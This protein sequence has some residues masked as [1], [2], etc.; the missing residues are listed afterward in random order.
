MDESREGEQLYT[1]SDLDV[2]TV[3][4]VYRGAVRKPFFVIKSAD[5]GKDMSDELKETV[6]LVKPEV[7][8]TS[9][10]VNAEAFAEQ[11][12]T[13]E[14][15]F[16]EQLKAEREKREQFSN[17]YQ[18]ERHTRRL[19]EYT[20]RVSR[21]SFGAEIEQ[22]AEDLIQL[23]DLDPDLHSRMLQRFSS[24][25]EQMKSG[26]LFAQA[27]RAGGENEGKHPFEMEV[28]KVQ[29][30]QFSG[31]SKA[32]GYVKAFEIV[33]ETNPELGRDFDKQGR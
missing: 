21:F 11:L 6:E 9:G 10:E 8:E 26:E 19:S 7:V 16:A 12:R 25:D 1:L 30:E 22:F 17:L 2:D 24:I 31:L 3:G 23:E 4:L 15:R 5:G 18:K 14:E 28:E 20:D 33:N 13:T 29:R 32:E 27:S